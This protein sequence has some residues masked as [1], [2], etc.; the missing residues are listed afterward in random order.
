MGDVHPQPSTDHPMDAVARPDPVRI[1]SATDGFACATESALVELWALPYA[2]A[3]QRLQWLRRAEDFAASTEAAL[4]AHANRFP[5]WYAA[6][7]PADDVALVGHRIRWIRRMVLRRAWRLA[8]MMLP[9]DDAACSR[10]AAD[11]TR[12]V[13]RAGRDAA[14]DHTLR[15]DA[16]RFTAEASAAAASATGLPGGRALRIAAEL[17]RSLCEDLRIFRELRPRRHPGLT[18]VTQE[19]EQQTATDCLV[20]RDGPPGPR[21]PCGHRCTCVACTRRLERCP[22]CRTAFARESVRWIDPDRSL[23]RGTPSPGRTAEGAPSDA[24]DGRQN[25]LLARIAE[26]GP[27]DA[28]QETRLDAG[29]G[30]VGKDVARL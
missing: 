13:G 9:S 5:C 15:S 21:L 30:V 12:L 19:Q 17:G 1:R 28:H 24:L 20:C 26:N 29:A 27:H 22:L 2:T 6:V 7:D 16:R 11:L 23:F 4:V 25:H 3:T 18:L 10:F 14:G 8:R